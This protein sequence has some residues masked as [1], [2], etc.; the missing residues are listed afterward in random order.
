VW[1]LPLEKPI[2]IGKWI[3]DSLKAELP[4]WPATWFEN[5]YGRIY[6]IS[7]SLKR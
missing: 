4:N 6:Q 3:E 7:H 1:P 5:G 2:T